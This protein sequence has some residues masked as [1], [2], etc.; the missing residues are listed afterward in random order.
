MNWLIVFVGGGIGSLLRFGIGKLIPFKGLS[1][2]WATFLSNFLACLIFTFALFAIQKS[3]KNEWIQP[4]V[5]VG[6]CG[7]FSTFS[8]FSF[9]NFQIVLSIIRFALNKVQNGVRDGTNFPKWC[10]QG[11]S[12]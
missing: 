5:L 2:P 8:T 7:G 3:P 10:F 9:E 1:F 4:L 12:K 11:Q 6:I